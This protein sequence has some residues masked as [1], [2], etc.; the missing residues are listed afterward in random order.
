[1]GHR[2]IK[3]YFVTQNEGKLL[4]ARQ[5]LNPLGIEVER[6]SIPFIE[7]GE[8]T[9]KEISRIKLKQALMAGL[10]RVMVDDAG[11][12][13]EAYPSF[14]G[15]LSKR[16]FQQIG[17]RG[18]RKLLDGES[19]NAW[20]EG[21]V[22]ISWNGKIKTFLGVTRGRIIEHFPDQ[23]QVDVQFPFDPI[24]IP[25][26]ADRVMNEMSAD[27]RLFYSYRRKALEK[28]AKWLMNE[29]QESSVK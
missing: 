8:G 21:A 18:I 27:E 9:V 6:V 5:Y 16:I 7:P 15:V 2:K 19:R 25:E 20:F 13:L 17:Y 23:L 29:I 3:L 1:M 24:F 28:L 4:E 26:G 11:I 22:S 10:E 14:P 12:Y